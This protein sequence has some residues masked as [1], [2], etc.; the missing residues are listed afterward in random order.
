MIVFPHGA[1]L[2]LSEIVVQGQIVIVQNMRVKQEVACR[3]I[4][5]KPGA[6]AK[7]YVEVE[8][9]QAAP[10]FWGISFP[11]ESIAPRPVLAETPANE[12]AAIGTMAPVAPVAM[13]TPAASAETSAS[14]VT[15][16]SPMNA[17]K[18]LTPETTLELNRAIAASFANLRETAKR[19][20][21]S[22]SAKPAAEKKEPAAKPV[23]ETQPAPVSE[24]RPTQ[25]Q[26]APPAHI[27][28]APPAPRTAMPP[29]NRN[30]A[31]PVSAPANS[32]SNAPGN[33]QTNAPAMPQVVP[34]SVARSEQ[35]AQKTTR[36]SAPIALADAVAPSDAELMAQTKQRSQFGTQTGTQAERSR[37]LKTSEATISAPTSDSR[38]ASGVATEEQTV[39]SDLGAAPDFGNQ[40]LSAKAAERSRSGKN[41]M[42]LVA[43]A[44]IV[45]AAGV[46]SYFWYAKS[47]RASA[48]LSVSGNA[49]GNSAATVSGASVTQIPIAPNA[50]AS[51]PQPAPVSAAGAQTPSTRQQNNSAR[52]KSAKN[53]PAQ[54]N[55][56]VKNTNNGATINNGNNLQPIEVNARQPNALPMN[57]AA[58]QAP[59]RNTTQ[60]TVSAPD[61]GTAAPPTGANANAPGMAS[62]ISS[63]MPVAP[64]PSPGGGSVISAMKD[65]KLISSVMPVYPKAATVRGDYGEVMVTA[66]VNELGKVVGA[67]ATSGPPTLR[68]AAITA[69]SQ[70]RYQPALLNGKPVTSQI[71]VRLMFNP[72][73]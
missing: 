42:I 73:K 55:P 69:V 4:S 60:N 5:S 33:T 3:V 58:P 10:G 51:N 72:K 20:A 17:P 61:L 34:Q 52:D 16:A 62:I 63:S 27:A 47:H 71:V 36:E 56:S 35:R 23:V 6:S 7:G 40:L 50:A 2:R 13:G 32:T 31:P 26:V 19:P 14:S 57:I 54:N 21:V 22:E 18:K 44:A 64:P 53:N 24:T 1:V 59:S 9:S 67:K 39:L 45:V 46:G 65:A 29:A 43:A 48:T 12:E 38:G 30:A 66:T 28:A 11:G 15:P 8:F 70:W 37:T 68:E 25:A 41:R 49:P